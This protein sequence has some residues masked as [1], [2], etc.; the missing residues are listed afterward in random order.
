[1]RREP[2][3]GMR[4]VLKWLR[5]AQGN[6]MMEAALIAPLLFAITFAIIDFAVVF[7]VYLSLSNGVS[8]ATRFAVTG[9]VFEGQGR[10][11]SIKAAMRA[12]TPS[13]RLDDD[14]FQFSH[15]SPGSASWANGV[16][17]PDDVE[18]VTVLYTHNFL[19][20]KPL[21]EGGQLQIRVESAMKNEALF[22]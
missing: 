7:Y 11:A 3:G 8:Q 5:D 1:M 21:F 13:L 10:E 14:A 19:V 18:K 2:S 20:L 9:N 15:L 22:E 6:A 16:G 17:G 4:R 12:A